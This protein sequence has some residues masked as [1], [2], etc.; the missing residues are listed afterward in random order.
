M[1]SASLSNLA[2]PSFIDR[3]ADAITQ[4]MVAAFEAATGRTL[5]P[6]QPE[7]VEVDMVAYREMLLRVGIQEAA[8]LNLLAYTRAP[9]LDHKAAFFGV[10]RLAA[11]PARTT[12]RFSLA[13]ARAD[14]TIIPAGTQVASKDNAVKYATTAEVL[15]LAGATSV[16]AVVEATTT[17]V[18]GNGYLAGEVATLVTAIDGVTV[19]NLDTTQGGAAEEID[20]RLRERTRLA[21]ESWSSAGPY[22]AYRFW[23]LSA[24]QA[25]V[26]VA[27]LSPS[28]GVVAVYPL[29][30][31]GLP[32]DTHLDVVAAVLNQKE[33]RP[34]TDQVHVLAPV[35]VSYAIA[36]GLTLEPDAPAEATRAAVETALTTLTTTWASS[37]GQDIMTSRIVATAAVDGVH[38][39][40]LTSPAASIQL[41]ATQWAHCTGITVT[42]EG[43]DG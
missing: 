7:R 25:I 12:V 5:F 40:T 10:T 24:H 31:D 8:L 39:V 2:E 21:P 4:A 29:M 13:T 33:I 1:R 11:Q 3:D 37:L 18:G 22:N 28:P 17:G 23:A 27:V 42:V 34:L 38:D 36:V 41:T 26:D 6:A 30:S 16:D 32:T 15:I 19:T 14:A 20:D 35:E 43:Y 9:V